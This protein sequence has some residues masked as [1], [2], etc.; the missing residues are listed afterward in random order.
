[1]GNSYKSVFP[2]TLVWISKNEV[3]VRDG[4]SR[5]HWQYHGKKSVVYA[6]FTKLRSTFQMNTFCARFFQKQLFYIN[7]TVGR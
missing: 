4:Q 3:R 7:K 5:R 2:N 6:G 1:M